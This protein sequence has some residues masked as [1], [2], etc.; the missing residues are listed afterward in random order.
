MPSESI[1]VIKDVREYCIS[2]DIKIREL[3]KSISG[4]RYFFKLIAAPDMRLLGTVT[5]GDL[6]R[7]LLNGRE[8]DDDASKCMNHTPLTGRF[9]TES[10]NEEMLD[11]IKGPVAFLPILSPEGKIEEILIREKST[12]DISTALIMAGG[13]GTRLGE[14]TQNVPKPLLRVGGRPILSHVIDTVAQAGIGELYISVH[15]LKEQFRAFIEEADADIEIHLIEESTPLGTAGALGEVRESVDGPI[16]MMNGDVLTNTNLR[17]MVSYHQHLPY[18]VTI[19]A[20]RYD[21]Q[22]PYG[23]IEYD[24]N[25]RVL[26]LRE[27]PRH[28]HFVA[29]GIYILG[30]R[31]ISLVEKGASLDMPD[32]LHRA[33]KAGIEIGT[34][35]IHEYW[36]DLGRPADLEKAEIDHSNDVIR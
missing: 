8:P 31:T 35:P 13:F 32:L 6:R 18:D 29:A 10:E 33:A 23:V 4:S 2:P 9:G 3:L 22:V 12:V 27:K 20:A 25:G 30:P 28:T 16:L 36:M 24:S 7:G 5:N 1:E 17:A 34:Y 26:D 14:R 15:Y 21:L 11:A 19:G